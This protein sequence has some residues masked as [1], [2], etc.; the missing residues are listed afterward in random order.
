MLS[1]CFSCYSGGPILIG[2]DIFV[3]QRFSEK[4][5]AKQI[6]ANMF[7][8]E[9]ESSSKN[10]NYFK[11]KPSRKNECHCAG[12]KNGHSWKGP[13]AT[14]RTTEVTAAIPVTHCVTVG[15]MSGQIMIA[16]QALAGPGKIARRVD[17]NLVRGPSLSSQVDGA[18]RPVATPA[19][20]RPAAHSH[21]AQA[22][23]CTSG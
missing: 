12:A 6:C 11:I 5:L 15:L 8:F 1:L 2:A 17:F 13:D 16:V 7:H 4:Y 19:G 18:S 22:E 3:T 9:T 20:G 21:K 10:E 23:S 14:R